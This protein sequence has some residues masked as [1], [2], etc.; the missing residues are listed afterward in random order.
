MLDLRIQY[1][2][3]RVP[4]HALPDLIGKEWA[5]DTLSEYI[6]TLIALLD[7]MDGDVD[8]EDGGDREARETMPTLPRYAIDQST[9]P[10]NEAEACRHWQQSQH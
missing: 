3:R 10:V 5:R 7:D 8:L 2:R 1:G 6:E 9:G 4:P